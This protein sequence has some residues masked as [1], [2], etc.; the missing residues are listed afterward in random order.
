MA[1]ISNETGRDEVYVVNVPEVTRK[2]PV[3]NAG[4]SKPR[5][6]RDG[7]ELFFVDA[8]GML[9]SVSIG[10]TQEIDAGV[11]KP[12]F[13]PQ[14]IPSDGWNYAV[15]AGGQRF[16]VMRSPDNAPATPITVV[17]N[18]AEALKK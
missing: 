16:L 10:G 9:M 15:S 2:W 17:L 5:W 18:W 14:A 3:S 8:A 7:S 6:R 12:L 4:G 13:E 11:P 1:Y